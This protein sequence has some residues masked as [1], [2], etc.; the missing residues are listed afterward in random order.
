MEYLLEAQLLNP[1]VE[2]LLKGPGLP[3]RWP[4]GKNK[5]LRVNIFRYNFRKL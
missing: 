4:T 5:A 3:I 1:T 2:N